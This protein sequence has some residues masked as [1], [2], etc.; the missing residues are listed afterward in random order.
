MKMINSKKGLLGSEFVLWFFRFL[1]IILIVAS[2]TFM[3]FAV[4]RKNYDVRDSEAVLI[5]ENIMDCITKEGEITSESLDNFQECINANEEEIYIQM[6]VFNATIGIK[7]A[8]FGRKELK[9]YCEM[10]GDVKQRYPPSCLK[11]MYII[12][13]DDG[14]KQTAYLN[15]SIAIASFEKNV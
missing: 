2:V 5:S 13:F 15:M 3:V 10:L 14:F 8:E 12:N 9:I 7:K 4:Q 11:Q 1:I 6:E